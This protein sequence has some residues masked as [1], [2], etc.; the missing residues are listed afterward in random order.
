MRV[1]AIGDTIPSISKCKETVE[2]ALPYV[3][4]A[5][6]ELEGNVLIFCNTAE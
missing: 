4:T 2:I 6:E 3:T 5:I 1:L